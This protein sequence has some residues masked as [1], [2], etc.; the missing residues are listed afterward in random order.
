MYTCI[1]ERTRIYLSGEQASG[2]DADA[3][4]AALRATAGLWNDRSESGD[5]YVDRLRSGRRL[6]SLH[7]DRATP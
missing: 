5:A 2:R 1:M 7:P 6:Q 3:V 4:R